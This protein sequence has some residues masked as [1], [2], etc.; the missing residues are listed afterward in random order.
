VH[1][2]GSIQGQQL[3]LV[4][5]STGP[6]DMLNYFKNLEDELKNPQ[7]WKTCNSSANHRERRGRRDF[8]IKNNVYFDLSKNFP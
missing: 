8:Q 4:N 5:Y 2:F 7:D 1:D 6:D 3:V